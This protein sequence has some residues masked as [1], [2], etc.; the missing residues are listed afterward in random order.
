MT[1]RKETRLHR[2][3]LKVSKYIESVAKRG[4]SFDATLTRVLGLNVDRDNV[5]KNQIAR[6]PEVTERI[7]R[8]IDSYVRTGLIRHDRPYKEFY[9]NI[10]I[11]FENSNYPKIHPELFTRTANGQL[12]LAHMVRTRVKAYRIKYNEELSS[13]LK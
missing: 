11:E 1:N 8:E 6:N 4:E 2:I 7:D 9:D 12:R 5:V 3:S 10:K 13:K